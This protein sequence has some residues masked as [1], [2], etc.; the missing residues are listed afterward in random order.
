MFVYILAVCFCFL[1][2]WMM[3]LCSQQFV[4]VHISSYILYQMDGCAGAVC[5]SICLGLNGWPRP[6][7]PGQNWCIIIIVQIKCNHSRYHNHQSY[8][9]KYIMSTLI[10][11][12]VKHDALCTVII[13][14]LE[15]FKQPKK[16]KFK[17]WKV[18]DRLLY[19]LE[20]EDSTRS[21]VFFFKLRN[22]ENKRGKKYLIRSIVGFFSWGCCY[23]KFVVEI[24]WAIKRTLLYHREWCRLRLKQIFSSFFLSE[25]IFNCKR[26]KIWVILFN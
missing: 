10:A 15:N 5:C 18:K 16:R 9:L 4:M 12:N 7:S 20:S 25:E 3:T 11:G 2:K 19:L 24:S 26:E 1:K 17:Q 13:L 23:Y 14:L 21:N 22:A 6:N 8:Q